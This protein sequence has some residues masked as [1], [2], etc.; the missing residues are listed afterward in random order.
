[1]STVVVISS[2]WMYLSLIFM[3]SLATELTQDSADFQRK[4]VHDNVN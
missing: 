3:C 4:Q 2:V 1:M